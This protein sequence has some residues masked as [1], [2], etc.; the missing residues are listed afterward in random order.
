MTNIEILT[1]QALQSID[2]KMCDQNEIN[3]EQRRYEIA[4]DLYIQTCQQAKL[5]G[6]NTAADVFRSAAWLSRVAADYLIE[7]LKK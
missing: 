7:V 2:C 1:H 5:E 3:W 4:K 6:D